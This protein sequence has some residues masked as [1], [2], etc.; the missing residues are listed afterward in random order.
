MFGR[1]WKIYNISARWWVETQSREFV[2]GWQMFNQQGCDWPQRERHR[3]QAVP[4]EKLHLPM[5][6]I[7]IPH[8]YKGTI[9]FSYLLNLNICLTVWHSSQDKDQTLLCATHQ[10]SLNL[11]YLLYRTNNNYEH[12]IFLLIF[13]TTQYKPNVQVTCFFFYGNR[14]RR[15][16]EHLSFVYLG[17]LNMIF[18]RILEDNHIINDETRLEST[19]TSPGIWNLEFGLWTLDFFDWLRMT[20]GYQPDH[21]SLTITFLW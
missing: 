1:F 17:L 6:H 2:P 3:R 19:G 7:N 8:L 15:Q 18:R 13:I 21:S 5:K 9:T 11:Q 14:Y 4:K 20:P 10:S 16:T 12:N